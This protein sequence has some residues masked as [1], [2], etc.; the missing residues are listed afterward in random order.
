M[1]TTADVRDDL[2]RLAGALVLSLGL[3]AC[4]GPAAAPGGKAA[5]TGPPT[6]EVVRVL[7]QAVD[8]TLSLPGELNP[9]QAVAIYPRVT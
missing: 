9:Y 7:Q 3:S 8:A 4:G 5:A 1:N 6:I 2:Q